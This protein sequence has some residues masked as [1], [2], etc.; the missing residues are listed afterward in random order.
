MPRLAR[1]ARLIVLVLLLT[2]CSADEPGAG[3]AE[4]DCRPSDGLTEA[5]RSADGSFLLVSGESWE[6]CS[7][8]GERTAVGSAKPS[9]DGEPRVE[10]VAL[11]H[12]FLVTPEWGSYAVLGPDGSLSE[13]VDLLRDE[14]PVHP[15][16]AGDRALVTPIGPEVALRP[17]TGEI[18]TPTLLAR[19][20]PD[21]YV[22]GVTPDA[23]GLDAA[24]RLWA[25]FGDEVRYADGERWRRAGPMP[26]RA[27]TAV[28]LS[29]VTA[30]H[31]VALTVDSNL[32]MATA[33]HVR[34]LGAGGAWSDIPLPGLLAEA[35]EVLVVDERR[36]LVP[37]AEGPA[38]LDLT[39]GTLEPVEVP[40]QAPGADPDAVWVAPGGLVSRDAGRLVWS[41][42]GGATWEP[43]F[44]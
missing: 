15:T 37:L 14:L 44:H 13:P 11:D 18:F 34:G 4:K 9:A 22:P 19:D 6:L 12:G 24:G 39:E 20:D 10:A 28:G 41:A 42:D 21:A 23:W 3:S 7:P 8:R 43:A 26:R 31:L 17:S 16:E 1:L 27:G 32:G 33:L 2:G 30:E 40:G 29:V 35:G 36:V 5:V 38:V 25:Q